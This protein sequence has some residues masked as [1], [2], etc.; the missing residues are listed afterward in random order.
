MAPS[1]FFRTVPPALNTLTE[2]DRHIH[3]NSH[4]RGIVG[5][6]FSFSAFT[7]DLQAAVLGSTPCGLRRSL[8]KLHCSACFYPSG[9]C[10]FILRRLL[11]TTPQSMDGTQHGLALR[12]TR[13]A[14]E[15]Y[16]QPTHLEGQGVAA[17]LTPKWMSKTY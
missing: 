5:W 7:D 9:P 15:L 12:F 8:S 6:A 13:S 14:S 2:R 3:T 16:P 1:A 11:A 10:H 4:R 17:R